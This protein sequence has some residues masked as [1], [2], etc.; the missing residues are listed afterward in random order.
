MYK[1]TLF[2]V[3]EIKVILTLS[4][5][6]WWFVEKKFIEL[7][8]KYRI[9]L[10]RKNKVCTENENSSIPQMCCFELG[11]GCS[12]FKYTLILAFYVIET[13]S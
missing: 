5:F 10:L 9:M 11:L 8:K 1:F 6:P 12:N 2:L 13:S 4:H 7:L 3:K